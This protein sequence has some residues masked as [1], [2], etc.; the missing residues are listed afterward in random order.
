MKNNFNYKLFGRTK[1]RKKNNIVNEIVNKI[2][3]NKI[4]SSDYNVID[5]G[6]GYGESTLNLA[7]ND[8]KK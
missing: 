2:K 4:D 5:I 1:G 3:V 7:I 8:K 6:S